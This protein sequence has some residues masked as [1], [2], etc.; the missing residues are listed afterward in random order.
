MKRLLY[1]LLVCPL[2]PSCQSTL[3]NPQVEIATPLG[4]ITAE[5][6]L[7][8]AP[9]SAGAFLRNVDQGVYN[10]GRAGFYRVV[11]MD[12]QPDNKVRIEVVQG[13]VDR[14]TGDTSVPY[15]PHETTA[16]TGLTHL[17][18]SLSMAREE[19]GTANT[20]FSICIG[21]QPELDFG[22]RRNPDGQGFAVF[23]RVI[24]GMDVARAIQKLPETG[25][26]LDREVPIESVK[27]LSPEADQ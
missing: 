22:G 16:M 10:G 18:G 5:V 26:Y 21:P 9:L 17:D 8:E 3:R 2:L 7:A 4:A 11:H 23:G 6:Y 15:I 25:Q 27:R 12:N 19:P 14:E 20:E 1:A 24:D 13:G